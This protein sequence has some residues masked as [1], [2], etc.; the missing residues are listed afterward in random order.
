MD[1]DPIEETIAN[2]ELLD[3]DEQA[4]RLSELVDELTEEL[5]TTSGSSEPVS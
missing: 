4:K 2:L 5:E 1:N 3:A